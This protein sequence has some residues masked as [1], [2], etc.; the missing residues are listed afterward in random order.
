VNLIIL[1]C[2]ALSL[3]P[4]GIDAAISWKDLTEMRKNSNRYIQ[5]QEAKQSKRELRLSKK[6]KELINELLKEKK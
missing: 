1:Q 5:K 4:V 6:D 3:L 2:L